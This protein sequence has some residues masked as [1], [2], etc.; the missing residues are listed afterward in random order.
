[1]AKGFFFSVPIFISKSVG[2]ISMGQQGCDLEMWAPMALGL[3]DISNGPA[4][5]DSKQPVAQSRARL[6]RLG[7][8]CQRHGM[9]YLIFLL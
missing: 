3:L 4:Q 5:H 7:M 1:M 8:A 2:S 6:V 9:G